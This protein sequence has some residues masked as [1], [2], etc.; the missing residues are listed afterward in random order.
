MHIFQLPGNSLYVWI[1]TY[2]SSNPQSLKCSGRTSRK[3]VSGSQFSSKLI[4]TKPPQIPLGI[5][6][7]P[8]SSSSMWGKSQRQGISY[9]LPSRFQD[10]PWNGQRKNCFPEPDEPES[11]N[12]MPLCGHEF[13]NARISLS[14]PLTTIAL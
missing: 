11:A 5:S 2:R 8:N 3:S 4:K 7:R 10:M 14:I 13:T 12:C 9:K 6:V 1:A